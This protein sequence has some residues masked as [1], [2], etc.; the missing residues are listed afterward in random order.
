MQVDINNI[1]PSLEND[2]ILKDFKPAFKGL[3]TSSVNGKTYI[4]FI[5]SE[6]VSDFYFM[7]FPRH[8][9][10]IIKAVNIAGVE[11]LSASKFTGQ[12]YVDF[13][14][15]MNFIT[16]LEKQFISPLSL[17]GLF[18][19]DYY[20]TDSAMIDNSW[21]Y[22]LVFKPKRK[23]EFT[24]KGD[25]WVADTS[26]ALKR[27]SAQMSETANLAFVS[28]FYVKHD[29]KRIN[30][31][32]FP[33][34]EE[35]FIDFNISK[36]TTGFFGRKFT[37]RKNI[38]LNPDIA[39][40]FFS[41]TEFREIETDKNAARYDST[42]WT[43]LRHKELSIKEKAVYHM[44][45]TIKKT[46][47]FRK[48]ENFTYFI[49]TGY[50]RRN[51]IEFGP[52]YK[53]YSKNAI[54]GSR[55]RLGVRTSNNFSKTI[56]LNA[57]SAFG[58]NDQ[59]IKFG[60]GTKWKV[61]SNPWT[62]AQINYYEDMI[63]LGAALN[64]FGTDNIFA[65][66]TDNDKLLYLKNVE[67]G[68][69]HDIFKSLTGAVSFSHKEIF[70]TDSI[71]FV[72]SEGQNILLLTASEINISARFGIN[73]EYIE[74]VFHR[75]SFGSLYPIIE[76][77]YTLGI[78]GVYHYQKLTLG[79]KHHISYGFAGKTKYYLEGGI[80]Y[81]NV[82]FPLL[83]LHEA[84]PGI[85]YDEYSFSLMNYYEFAS[86]KYVGFFAEHHFNGLFLNKIP[87]LRKL[88]FR[89]V[90]YAKGVWG[91]LKEENIHL[92]RFPESLSNVSKPYIEIGAGVENILNFLSI[93]YFRRV[94]HIQKDGIRRN[95]LVLG[96]KVTF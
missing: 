66:A 5:I 90:I 45:D 50:I 39:P 57:Y 20:L 51:F 23:Y 69:E 26:F 63:Q 83:K 1:N 75:Q 47:A 71:A 27:I 36:V 60:V 84:K 11:N 35:F 61:K 52:Y 41:L 7:N 80:I 58:I 94:T 30:D 31:F 48:I 77:K 4:P 43:Q 92:M 37:S 22:H 28:D 14:F 65:I 81:G 96:F 53:I 62:L 85:A 44:V 9:K 93:N 2:P 55:L 29:Y 33:E 49:G 16:I 42:A 70:P 46:S 74:S 40:S 72:G 38:I 24:F 6:T 17:T 21:C 86:D 76:F 25:M 87:L 73:E 54:E 78:P 79:L 56:E 15:Y 95:G 59:K 19:Y 12:M 18:T 3:D 91:S 89:E 10:E 34:I 8:R 68:I 32:Y 88:K 82:P 13:N 67:I 64:N